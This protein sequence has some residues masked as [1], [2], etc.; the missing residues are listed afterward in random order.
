M[1]CKELLFGK[2]FRLGLSSFYMHE[3]MGNQHAS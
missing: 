3:Q 2:Q 1:D